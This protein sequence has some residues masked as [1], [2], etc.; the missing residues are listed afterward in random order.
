M[1]CIKT[2]TLSKER[3]KVLVT[4]AVSQMNIK[5][6]SALNNGECPRVRFIGSKPDYKSKFGLAFGDYV[7]AYNPRSQQQWNDVW[8]ARTEPC[9]ALYLR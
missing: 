9:I 8:Q 6:T 1:C 5:I 3:I 4:Y 2:Y 7:E